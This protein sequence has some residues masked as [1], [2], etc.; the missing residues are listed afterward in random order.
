M[1]GIEIPIV[2]TYSGKGVSQ[3]ESSL[4]KLGSSAM[5]SLAAVASV[6]A[7]LGFAKSAISAFANE[8]KQQ[9]IMLNTLSNQGWGNFSGM[10]EDAIQKMRLATGVSA[11]ELRPAFDK[12]FLATGSA[13]KSLS[14]LNVAM[15]VSKG[16]GKDL[17]MVAQAM[18]KGFLGNTTSLTR[19]GA[20]LDKAV[21]AT[22]NMDLI[23][24]E[25]ERKLGGS[26]A[27]AAT[28]FSGQIAILGQNVEIAKESIGSHLVD[29][30]AKAAGK[31]GIGGATDAINSMADALN[32]I[33]DIGGN[34]AGV[35]NSINGPLS[36]TVDAI[37]N[38]IFGKSLMA[39]FDRK[40]TGAP[41][42][43]AG[44]ASPGGAGLAAEAARLARLPKPKT[45]LTATEIA[46][47]KTV[48]E[49]LAADKAHLAIQKLSNNFDMKRIEL[50]AV[51]MSN[52]TDAQKASAQAQ[53]NLM[54]AQDKMTLNTLAGS[55]AALALAN[56]GLAELTI[57]DKL[58]V[59]T[60]NNIAAITGTA[61][62]LKGFSDSLTTYS[63][64]IMTAASSWQTFRAGEQGNGT[65]GLPYTNQQGSAYTNSNGSDRAGGVS[66]TVII[67]TPA[68][69]DSNTINPAVQE[70]MDALARNGYA[71]SRASGTNGWQ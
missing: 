26:A 18:S 10:V 69:L 16:T 5:K 35:F 28:T 8:Q 71:S 47:A 22:G 60:S 45:P 32:R 6:T 49:K 64:Q 54:D 3:A 31:N 36:R 1:A 2:A 9:A 41:K 34:I 20:G 12:L 4:S 65:G 42:A 30:L 63:A 24:A 7:A 37:D 27:I 15:D 67:Q 33:I 50:N 48:K 21:L 38:F 66:P 55:S 53:L 14:A 56:A 68:I 43:K 11:D 46:A 23:V 52:A 57:K 51:L 17:N 44:Q 59:A 13:T 19:L 25:L 29:A 39:A 58:S 61:D 40:L 62:S 70:A